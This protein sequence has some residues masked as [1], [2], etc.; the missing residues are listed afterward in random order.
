MNLRPAKAAGWVHLSSVIALP[1]KYIH[2][3]DGLEIMIKK[4]V[5]IKFLML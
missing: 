3:R 1:I 4:Y 5:V 2:R